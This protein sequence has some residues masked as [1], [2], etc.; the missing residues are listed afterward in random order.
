MY[1]IKDWKFFQEELKEISQDEIL[2]ILNNN[3]KKKL[4][5]EMEDFKIDSSNWEKVKWIKT[6]PEGDV[7]EDEYWNQFFTW[8]WAMR[9]T[10]KVWKII[11][12]D[13]E[14]DEIIGDMN[15]EE[16]MKK[17]NIDYV[18]VLDSG[19]FY[20]RGYSAYLWSSTEHSTTVAR[21]RLLNRNNTWVYRG[22]RDKSTYGFSVRCI[23]D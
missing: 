22:Y 10:K 20:N 11:P 1:I 12:T 3:S 16:F 7:F 14:F 4:E 17:Y 21:G 5:L 18:G 8:D 6:N 15:K 13:E 9:E 19:A 23:K 2:S